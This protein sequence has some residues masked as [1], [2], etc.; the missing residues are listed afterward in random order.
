MRPYR[1]KRKDNGEWVY[2]HYFAIGDRAFIV[3]PKAR[4]HN[5]YILSCQVLNGEG[6]DFVEVDPA[7]VGQF[8][9]LKD[10]NGKEIY[11]GDIVQRLG[12]NGYVSKGVIEHYRSAFRI[13]GDDNSY[14]YLHDHVPE[15]QLEVI[16]NVHDKGD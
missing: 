14:D 13:R 10:K 3:W 11:G 12:D 2:G 1:G 7:T 6:H 5:A 16:G 9:G 4:Y 8:T 15:H